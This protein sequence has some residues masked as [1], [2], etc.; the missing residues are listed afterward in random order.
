MHPYSDSW[1]GSNERSPQII[2]IQALLY[3]K[4]NLDINSIVKHTNDIRS[5]QNE[6]VRQ[7]NY[8]LGGCLKLPLV[9]PKSIYMNY[10]KNIFRAAL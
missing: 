1:E 3:E 10:L 2:E 4:R 8:I 5:T 6:E 9:K 7:N